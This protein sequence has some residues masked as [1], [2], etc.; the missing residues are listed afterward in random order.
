VSDN[1]QLRGVDRYCLELLRALVALD[2]L[3]TYL[4]FYAPWQTWYPQA[5]QAPNVQMIRLQPPRSPYLRIPWQAVVLPRILRHYQPDVV[6]LTYTM[7]VWQRL[8]KTVMTVHDLSEFPLPQK[9]HFLRA[10]TRRLIARL[11]V[12]TVDHIVAVS[13]FTQEAL[14]HYLRVDPDKIAVVLEGV[15]P[16]EHRCT[17]CAATRRQYGLQKAYFLYVGVIERT[18]NIEG[19]LQAF[20]QL[21]ASIQHNVDLVLVGRPGNASAHIAHLIQVYGLAD[22]VHCLG[23]LDDTALACVYRGAKAFVFP[24][25]IEGFGLVLLEAMAHGIPVITSDRGALQEVAAD[26]ALLVNPYDVPAIQ[27]AMQRIAC[28]DS[29]GMELVCKG[30]VRVQQFTWRNTAQSMLDLYHTINTQGK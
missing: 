8:Y 28:D 23:Y 20:H 3:N 22:K 5:V 7:F 18:K 2:P 27:Q 15:T 4:V 24:S 12:R 6:H 25:L 9:F 26:A 29:V 1:A 13:H 11:A 17:A 19:I 16:Q 10:H 14:L 21:P 30:N